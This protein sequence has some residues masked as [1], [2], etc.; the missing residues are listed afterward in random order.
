MWTAASGFT[1]TTGDLKVSVVDKLVGQQYSDNA[2]TKF[3]KLPAYNSM[4]F[5]GSYSFGNIEFGLTI[6]NVLNSQSIAAVGIVDKCPI[7]AGMT[8]YT[9]RGTTIAGY[10][11]P[12][13]AGIASACA[14][15][16]GTNTAGNSQDT[17]SFQSSRFFQGTIKVHF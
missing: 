5:K 2:D 13:Y 4:D 1:Y 15:T 7:G 11:Q 8:D 17:Y 10:Q 9:A 6:N 14:A 12:T 3:Y 16:V